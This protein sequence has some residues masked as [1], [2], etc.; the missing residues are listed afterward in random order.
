[1]VS[2]NN[3]STE[4]P[5]GKKKFNN[6]TSD[7]ERSGGERLAAG[8]LEGRGEDH[9]GADV[10]V[11]L[12]A[13]LVLLHVGGEVAVH[14]ADVGGV[15]AEPDADPALVAQLAHDAGAHRVHRQV[16]DLVHQLHPAGPLQFLQLENVGLKLIFFVMDGGVNG[17]VVDVDPDLVGS[18]SLC[19]IRPF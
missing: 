15:E 11:V 7:P 17:S 1:M 8:P 5:I 3:L 6:C 14:Q 9:P 13:A 4:P 19:G 12:I 10:G 16:T 18:A 2:Y